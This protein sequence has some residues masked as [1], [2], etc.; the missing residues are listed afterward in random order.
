MEW[1]INVTIYE[2]VLHYGAHS[3]VMVFTF[4]LFRLVMNDFIWKPY[5][6]LEAGFHDWPRTPPIF[7]FKIFLTHFDR[8]CGILQT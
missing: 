6:S 8:S 1:K 7:G 5:T 2:R 3:N 4:N